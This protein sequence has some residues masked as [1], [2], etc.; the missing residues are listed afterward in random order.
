MDLG[1]IL[2]G[3]QVVLSIILVVSIMPQDTKSAVPSQF[4]GEGNQSYFKPKG[5]EAFL[6]RTTKVAG[7]LFFINA[8][9]M[10]LV[11]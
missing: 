11:K 7:V 4:G 1:M 2:M 10:L 8:I 9:A 3:V 6:A 5:K